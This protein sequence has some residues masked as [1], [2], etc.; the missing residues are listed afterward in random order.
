MCG[1]YLYDKSEQVLFDYYNEI[2]ERNPQV[3]TDIATDIIYPSNQVVTL[4]ANP[5][6]E[7]VPALTRWG[8]TGFKPSQLLINA[9]SETVREKKMFKEAF[10][11]RRVVFPMNGFY[12]FSDDKTPY[13]FTDTNSVI[14]VAGFYRIHPDKK[15]GLNQA[16]SIIIT[17][18]A[19]E[20]VSPIHD[21]MPLIIDEKDISKWIL[22][23][24]FAFN[25]QAQNNRHLQVTE[26]AK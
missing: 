25:Y 26:V 19:N 16:E 11:H 20:L 14:Y 4:G 22:D 9:R 3:E 7:I 5:D 23:D 1:R 24:Q 6:K 12:E 8:F 13:T 21:R 18:D 15:S 10:E 2:R 17:T